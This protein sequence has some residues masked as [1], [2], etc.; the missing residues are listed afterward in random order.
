M[1]LRGVTLRDRERRDE[2]RRDLGVENIMLKAR[3]ARLCSCVDLLRMGE[4]KKCESD[5]E[6]GS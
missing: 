2:I 6:Y 3:Q 1:W 4:D 5:D